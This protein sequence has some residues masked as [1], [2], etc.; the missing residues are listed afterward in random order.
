MVGDIR[1]DIDVSFDL[2]KADDGVEVKY[3]LSFIGEDQV[4]EFLL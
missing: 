1:G 4:L 2:T 3:T